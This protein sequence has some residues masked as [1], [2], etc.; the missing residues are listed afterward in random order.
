MVI[1]Q[2]NQVKQLTNQNLRLLITMRL[3]LGSGKLLLALRVSIFAQVS[4]LGSLK[5]SS[6]FQVC[7]AKRC[8]F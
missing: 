4:T 5:R 6:I 3:S 2:K 7:A 1:Q 8:E